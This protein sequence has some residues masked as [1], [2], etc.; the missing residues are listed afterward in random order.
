MILIGLIGLIWNSR[1]QQSNVERLLLTCK[2]HKASLEDTSD[3]AEGTAKGFRK[4]DEAQEQALLK[5]A[6]KS[7]SLSVPSKTLEEKL[8]I[9][10]K[11]A[12]EEQRI[13]F[14]LRALLCLALGFLCGLLLWVSNSGFSSIVIPGVLSGALLG[15]RLPEMFVDRALLKRQNDIT[16]DLV[17]IIC[18]IAIASESGLAMSDCVNKVVQSSQRRGHYNSVVEMFAEVLR[19]TRSGYGFPEALELT[20]KQADHSTLKHTLTV[21]REVHIHGGNYKQRL[22]D[23]AD[24]V[25]ASEHVRIT[26]IISRLELK[27]VGP[28]AMILFS[29]LIVLLI[30]IGLQLTTALGSP[31]NSGAVG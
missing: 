29:Y 23:L 16:S 8:L 1:R 25:E 19:L 24:S 30:Q 2:E 27:A 28:V 26:G 20:A 11:A 4:L 13:F 21:L 31:F 22:R 12:P 6:K 14:T 15:L 10:G 9:L 17:P 5:S 7:K 3:T 18:Q